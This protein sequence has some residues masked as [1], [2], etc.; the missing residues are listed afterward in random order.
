M[1][2]RLT[3]IEFSFVTYVNKIQTN[4][5]FYIRTD[6]NALT[7]DDLVSIEAVTNTQFAKLDQEE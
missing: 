3:Q 2:C 1:E 6:K 7:M 5:C 4:F